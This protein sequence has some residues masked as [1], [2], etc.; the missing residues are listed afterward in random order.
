[1]AATVRE[2]VLI[3]LAIAVGQGL[4]S[5]SITL[6]A[7]QIWADHYADTVQAALDGSYKWTDGDNRKSARA[8]A[9]ILGQTAAVLVAPPTGGGAPSKVDDDMAGRAMLAVKNHPRCVAGQ[10]KGEW[11]KETA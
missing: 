6:E 11:C 5:A 10:G 1:M 8:V 2:M 7:V 9:K 3:D 4:G